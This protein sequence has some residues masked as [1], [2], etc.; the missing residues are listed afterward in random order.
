L[1]VEVSFGGVRTFHLRLTSIFELIGLHFRE[2]NSWDVKTNVLYSLLF[3]RINR[4][5]LCATASSKT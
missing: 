1:L 5:N 4:Q 3:T 2:T